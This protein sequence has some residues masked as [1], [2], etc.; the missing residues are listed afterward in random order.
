MADKNRTDKPEAPEPKESKELARLTK[1]ESQAGTRPPNGSRSDPVYAT[2]SLRQ[3]DVVL[4]SDVALWAAIRNR[5]DAIRGER[6]EEF[7]NQV[8]CHNIGTDEAL[9][10]EE[11]KKKTQ[12]RRGFASQTG[13]VHWRDE[14]LR[15]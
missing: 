9:C 12:H 7:I 6:Y 13:G 5:T 10:P 11:T 3:A 14:R 8:L 2:I 4:T 15:C 1:T